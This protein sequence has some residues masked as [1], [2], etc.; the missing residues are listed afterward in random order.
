[1]FLMQ[2]VLSRTETIAGN[3]DILELFINKKYVHSRT[4]L[5]QT[6]T[7]MFA[8]MQCPTKFRPN[9][10]IF[11]FFGPQNNTTGSCVSLFGNY[12]LPIKIN[13]YV[14]YETK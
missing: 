8:K 1:M 13:V 4:K 10:S 9:I 7:I 11:S 2:L 14:Y 5:Y 12:Y 3:G 6:R